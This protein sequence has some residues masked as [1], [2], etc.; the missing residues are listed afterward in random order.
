M[1][2]LL[3]H[4]FFTEYTN[5]EWR[6]LK[7]CLCI[8]W[9][10]IIRHAFISPDGVPYPCGICSLVNCS[11]LVSAYT[12]HVFT[13]LALIL[14]LLYIFE[15][16][17]A[18]V[19]LLM[20]LLSLLCFTLEESNGILNRSGLYTMV[21]AAQSLA[22]FRNNVNLKTERIQFAVQIIAAGYMLAG[23]SKLRET[24]LGWVNESPQASLQMLKGYC[25]NYFNFGDIAEL[26]KGMAFAN[27]AIHHSFWV[28]L[29]FGL[30][31][32]FELFAFLAVKNKWRAFVYGLLLTAMHIG[33]FY[34]MHILIV[35]IFFPMLLFMVNPAY[36]GYMF[37]S[38]IKHKLWK[39]QAKP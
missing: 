27:F 2:K 19:T 24:G 9:F 23:I 12:G 32:L 8:V 38:A 34:F 14:S 33:I 1:S 11:P 22:Y 16:R 17:M 37:L 31:L 39:P 6:I 30:S 21:F 26:N 3:N 25:A 29:L 35:A 13:G 28:K 20:F 10:G 4:K 18:V 36:L 5:T 15:K 7:I